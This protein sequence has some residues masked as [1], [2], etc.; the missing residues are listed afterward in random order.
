MDRSCDF[1]LNFDSKVI[2]IENINQAD[3]RGKFILSNCK[4]NSIMNTPNKDILLNSKDLQKFNLKEKQ[5]FYKLFFYIFDYLF[6]LFF[7]LFS[8]C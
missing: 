3:R 1:N 8:S 5:M 6:S 4:D 7:R 2:S